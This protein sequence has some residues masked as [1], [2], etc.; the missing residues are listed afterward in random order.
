[1]DSLTFLPGQLYHTL[2]V[3]LLDNSLP[4]GEKYFTVELLN[5]TGGAAVGESSVAVVVIQHSDQAFGVFQFAE[6]SLFVT[7][8]ESEP[9]NSV[10]LTVCTGDTQVASS[11]S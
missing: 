3:S 1:M 5:P 8:E 9:Y 10:D 2:E 11:L 7:V 6:F 4:E